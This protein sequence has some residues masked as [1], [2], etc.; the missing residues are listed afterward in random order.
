LLRAIPVGRLSD[1]GKRRL[2]E[3][4]RKFDSVNVL[5]GPPRRDTPIKKEAIVAWKPERF[6]QGIVSRQKRIPRSWRERTD[7]EGKVGS[8]LT[9]VVAKHPGEYIRYLSRCDISTP[10]V[11]LDAIDSGM[12][13]LELDSELAL[14]A[15]R[16]FHR[17]GSD[18]SWRTV[19]MLEKVKPGIHLREA[20]SL[21]LDYAINGQ[22][23]SEE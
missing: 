19:R 18:W 9:E 12:M 22:G 11:F 20:F 10:K 2:A 14:E 8:T 1:A 6:L 13:N 5:Y 21:A 3:W 23:V 16:Q 17:L 15:A 7:H 4:E